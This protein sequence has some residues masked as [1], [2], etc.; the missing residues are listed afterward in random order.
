MVVDPAVLQRKVV[1]KMILAI[2]LSAA[3]VY[4]TAN[5]DPGKDL[6]DG[7]RVRLAACSLYLFHSML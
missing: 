5:S 2:P 1:A 4:S 6:A 7:H 3:A